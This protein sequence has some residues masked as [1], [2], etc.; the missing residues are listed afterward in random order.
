[1]HTNELWSNENKVFGTVEHENSAFSKHAHAQI[2]KNK[3][4]GVCKVKIGH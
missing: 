1:L 4:F 3:L 2:Q